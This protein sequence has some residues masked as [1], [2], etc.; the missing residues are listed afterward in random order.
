MVLLNRPKLLC[1]GWSLKLLQRQILGEAMRLF[2]P[3][4]SPDYSPIEEAF[5]KIKSVL[6]SIGARTRE[7]LQEALEYACT[8]ITA[9]D[10]IGWFRHC[11]YAV[12]D[13]H[14]QARA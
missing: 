13:E 12:P 5:S 4:Y 7:A 2:L 14:E 8:T 10:A 9:S 1:D 11:G 6:R 3:A